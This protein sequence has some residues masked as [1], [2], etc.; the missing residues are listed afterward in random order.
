M[1]WAAHSLYSGRNF[2]SSIELKYASGTRPYDR[3]CAARRR[4]GVR[5]R[6]GLT[7]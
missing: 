7:V 3:A 5:G 6:R 2:S 1:S 4:G